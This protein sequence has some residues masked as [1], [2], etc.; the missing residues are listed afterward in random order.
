MTKQLMATTDQRQPKTVEICSTSWCMAPETPLLRSI[1]PC[2]WEFSLDSSTHCI[3]VETSTLVQLQK[4]IHDL[5]RAE[6]QRQPTPNCWTTLNPTLKD[7]LIAGR[8]FCY[9]SLAVPCDLSATVQ[10]RSSDSSAD[11][12]ILTGRSFQDSF[13]RSLDQHIRKAVSSINAQDRP[14]V[15]QDVHTIV[16]NHLH[17]F[18]G[19]TIG[20]FKKWVT[21]ISK[22]KALD[23]LKKPQ[24]QNEPLPETDMT[25]EPDVSLVMAY[26][27]EHCR[28]CVSEKEWQIIVKY[29]AEDAT[30][31]QIGHELGIPTSTVHAKFKRAFDRLRRFSKPT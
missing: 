13:W 25:V 9:L 11:S 16:F 18:R 28:A 26:D 8:E 24:H 22:R 5:A 4:G 1:E 6:A 20:A 23:F 12:N 7:M 14:D 27:L 31:A 15:A 30:F 10:L 17:E 21:T 2:S 29:L 3:P 19:N